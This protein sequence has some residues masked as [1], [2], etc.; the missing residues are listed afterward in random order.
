M[1]PNVTRGAD[2]VNRAAH[3]LVRSFLIIAF[4]VFTVQDV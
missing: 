1:L 3:A 2:A 4:V